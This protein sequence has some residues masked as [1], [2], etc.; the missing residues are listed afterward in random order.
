MP[1]SGGRWR[2]ARSS[3]LRYLLRAAAQ[4]Y[5]VLAP[6]PPHSWCFTSVMFGKD[7]SAVRMIAAFNRDARHWQ[8]LAL[9]GL[10]IL[11]QT[12]TDFGATLWALPMAVSGAMLAQALGTWAVGGK[13]QW[14]SAL[15]TSLSLSILLRASA[16]WIW[17][18]A[19]L[20][21]VGTKFLIRYNNKHI[22]NPACIAIVSLSLLLGSDAWISPGQWGTAPLFAAFAIGFAALVLSSAKRLDIALGYL[23][24]HA[25]ALFGWAIYYE[26]PFAI[27]M[28]AMQNGALL[29]FAFFM[30][31]D[32]RS[33]PDSR[34]G[35]ILFAA[36][37][38]ATA[39]LLG[40]A[41]GLD[42]E[43]LYALALIAPL[44]IFMDR[45]FPAHRFEWSAS[46][47]PTKGNSDETETPIGGRSIGAPVTAH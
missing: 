45:I 24:F 37:V 40:W 35:R 15:I 25:I 41:T 26:D 14:K 13:F 17:F 47:S 39:S 31:T 23:A 3:V 11:S 32:P 30:I 36:T 2:T 6:F 5:R 21:A 1:V 22:F 7:A 44:T 46:K 12:Y 20:I 43:P 4:L 10:F 42:G 29:V 33:T 34:I 19:G 16:P 18:A 9:S 38:A 28:R 8:I 27:P